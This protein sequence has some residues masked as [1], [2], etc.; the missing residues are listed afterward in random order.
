MGFRKLRL[1]AFRSSITAYPASRFSGQGVVTAIDSPQDLARAYT[2]FS[3]VRA[4]G[5]NTPIELWHLRGEMSPEIEAEF[6]K[7]NVASKN[8]FDVAGVDELEGYTSHSGVRR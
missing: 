7:I 5:D 1:S 2:L 6:A 8:F 4:A 3:K